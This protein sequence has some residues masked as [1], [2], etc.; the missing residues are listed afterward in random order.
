MAEAGLAG[1]KRPRDHGACPVQRLHQAV[2]TYTPSW[3]LEP[4]REQPKQHR[5]PSP[6]R[7]QQPNRSRT[8]QG[9]DRWWSEIRIRPSDVTLRPGEVVSRSLE[10]ALEPSGRSV[11]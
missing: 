8:S 3:V 6:A 9:E 7:H 11:W 4:E 1:R 10:Y 5:A 2:Y